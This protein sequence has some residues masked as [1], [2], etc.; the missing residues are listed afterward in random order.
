MKAIIATLIVLFSLNTWATMDVTPDQM[1]EEQK[2]QLI[3]VLNQ[4]EPELLET[5]LTEEAL[6]WYIS[7]FTRGEFEDDVEARDVHVGTGQVEGIGGYD[8]PNAPKFL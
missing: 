7:Q 5:L 8:D 2:I 4:M 3:Q 1:T 6:D